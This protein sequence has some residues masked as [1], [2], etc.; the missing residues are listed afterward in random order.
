MIPEWISYLQDSE[1]N[2]QLLFISLLNPLSQTSFNTDEVVI[3]HIVNMWVE[4]LEELFGFCRLCV[5]Y[6]IE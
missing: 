3:E 6:K 5:F 4:L 1:D 2:I